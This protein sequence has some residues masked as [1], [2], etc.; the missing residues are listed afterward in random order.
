[1]PTIVEQTSN[2]RISVPNL[3]T[4]IA[5]PS[6]ALM[7]MAALAL[8]QDTPRSEPASVTAVSARVSITPTSLSP[9]DDEA[10]TLYI[11]SGAQAAQGL[12]GLGR[13]PLLDWY[14][15]VSTRDEE[16][17]LMMAFEHADW[18]RYESG[19]PAMRVVDLRQSSRVTSVQSAPRSEER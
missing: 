17:A 16:A 13:G 12:T 18:I 19:L 10:V 4:L 1:M 6:I 9:R 3:V 14:A 11:M 2:T 8:R 5:V 15:Y 7:L